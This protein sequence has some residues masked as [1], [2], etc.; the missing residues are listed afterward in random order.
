MG[1][2]QANNRPDPPEEHRFKPGQSG[3]PKGRPKGTSITARLRKVVEE[4][5]AGKVA[6]ALVKSAIDAAKTGDF[7]FWKE[8]V[9]RLDGPIVVK[10]EHSGTG[11]PISVIIERPAG[12]S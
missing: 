11:V 7:R 12:G 5:D 9:D 8:I 1:T 6:D 3:N 4:D 2:K 10:Q